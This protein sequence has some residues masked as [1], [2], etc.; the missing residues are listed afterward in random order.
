MKR[1]IDIANW[2]RKQHFEHFRR[3]DDPYFGLTVNVDITNLYRIS[4]ENK[5]SL[6]ILYFYQ[7]LTA[8][9]AIEEFRFRIEGDSVVCYDTI[10]ASSTIGRADGT[11]A[12]CKF[13]YD[14]DYAT[15]KKRCKLEIEKV[16]NSEGLFL[17]EEEDRPDI[18]YFSPVPWLQFTD[19]KH[20]ML[21]NKDASVPVISVGKYFE[22]NNKVMMPISISGNHALMDG[23]HIAQFIKVLEDNISKM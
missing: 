13:D 9:H 3:F 17:Y 7:I 15:F 6:F 16:Q 23:Y 22:N 8:V 2:K 12:F 18:I 11:F 5:E 19:M 4:K 21:I 14:S 20:P 10:Q 1:I